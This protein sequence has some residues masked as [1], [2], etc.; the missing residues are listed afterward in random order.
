MLG[1]VASPTT[2]VEAPALRFGPKVRLLVLFL[3]AA[4][5]V[6]LFMTIGSNGNWDFIIPF[7]GRKIV[8]MVAVG[9]AIAA[10]TILFQTI[11]DNRILTP[12]IM[13]FD[14]LYMLIQTVIVFSVGTVQLVQINARMLFLFEVLAMSAFAGALYWM[15]FIQSDR[16]LHLVVFV[17]IIFGVLFR[18][19][20]S[21]L[22]RMIDPTEFAVLQDIGFASFN[23]VNRELLALASA[24]IFVVLLVIWRMNR[25]LDALLLGRELSVNIGVEYRRDV[26]IVLTMVTIL[27]SVSTALVGPITFFGLLVAHL[28]YQT[29]GSSYHRYTIPAAALYS[30]IL[31][32]GGQMI[33]ERVFNFN[34][35]L[36]IMIDFAGGL[37]FIMLLLREG[38]KR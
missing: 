22:Q 36:S 7:R 33:L 37:L 31:L 34:S 18:S 11:T 14:A 25:V 12:S 26:M 6:T 9:F 38:R 19:L 4:G 8:S 5:A 13:G 23:T 24:V 17:G 32:V 29:I 27:V 20:T 10:S 21:L 28:A 2:G 3:L 15:L 35:S 16:S 30:V 1:N